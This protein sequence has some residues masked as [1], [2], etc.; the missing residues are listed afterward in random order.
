MIPEDF[1]AH[2]H[3]DE[4]VAIETYVLRNFAH[5]LRDEERAILGGGLERWWDENL[6]RMHEWGAH[7]R[8]SL[9]T[10]PPWEPAPFEAAHVEQVRGIVRRLRADHPDLALARCHHCERIVRGPADPVC[11]WC[12]TPNPTSSPAGRMR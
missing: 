7:A 8:S 3:Y 1:S 5:L 6:E 2:L 4:Q 9:T 12:R 11:P 10:A